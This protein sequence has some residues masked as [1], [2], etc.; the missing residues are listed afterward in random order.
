LKKEQEEKE[1]KLK[2]KIDERDA[3]WKVIEQ[4]EKEKIK[5][6]EEK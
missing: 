6:Q 3:C 1:K 2:K 4:N 5:K